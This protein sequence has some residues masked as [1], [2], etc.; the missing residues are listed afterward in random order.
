MAKRSVMLVGNFDGLHLGHQA[1]FAE[2]RRIADERDAAVVAVT[3]LRHPI[4]VL[5]PDHVPPTIAHR[6]QRTEL[7]ADAGADH[8]DWLDPTPG[9][10]ALTP[11]VFIR[12]MVERH[13]PVAMVE[14][15]NFRFGHRR[16]GDTRSLRELGERLGF[17]VAIVD[18]LEVTL[19]DKLRA[20][21]SSTLVRWLI[22]HGRVADA[23]ICLGRPWALRGDVVE[24]ERRGRELGLRT[25]NLDTTP[26]MLPADGVYADDVDID[27]Q[28]CLAAV[29]V[30]TK[31]TFG[32]SARTCEA[33]VL[34]YDGDLYGRALTLRMCRWLR[35][36]WAF[37]SPEQLRR[38]TAD[39]IERIRTFGRQDL[40]TPVAAT[41]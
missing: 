2:A 41:A 3:F 9:L 30:G 23:A 16:A 22:G 8:I 17:E 11:E 25:A 10:L 39:D 13:Q 28:R 36:Q 18:L 24:G 40:L 35:D 32:G 6:T 20:R 7:L 15:T 27:G 31:P 29:S 37:A 4:S 21:V 12:Q 33:H 1:L 5:R 38:Q 19:G 14:G 26:Q 34:D